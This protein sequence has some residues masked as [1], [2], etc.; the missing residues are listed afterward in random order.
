MSKCP[1]HGSG[2]LNMYT[3]LCR[4]YPALM[5]GLEGIKADSV[6]CGWRHSFIVDTTG[7][8]Y[9]CGWS[10]YGQLGHGNLDTLTVPAIVTGLVEPVRLHL[11]QWSLCV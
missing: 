10:K 9:S 7:K 5:Q 1:I 3:C 4:L 11:L 6:A 2:T 8:L